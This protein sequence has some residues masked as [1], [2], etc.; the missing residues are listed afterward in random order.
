MN[1]APDLVNKE[2]LNFFLSIAPRN[3][4]PGWNKDANTDV[5]I[6]A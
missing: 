2:Y 3:N 5:N 1:F 4:L 6:I